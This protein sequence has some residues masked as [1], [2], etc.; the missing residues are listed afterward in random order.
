MCNFKYVSS[1]FV[2][3]L[4]R[5]NVRLN[6][7]SVLKLVKDYRRFGRK[8]LLLHP[9]SVFLLPLHEHG[10]LLVLPLVGGGYVNPDNDS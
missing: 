1:L 5:S 6:I 10:H 4:L 2:S 7:W 9:V 3:K 8:V